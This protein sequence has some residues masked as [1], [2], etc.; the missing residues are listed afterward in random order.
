MGEAAAKALALIVHELATNSVKYGSLSSARGTLDLTCTEADGEIA[1]V[2]AERGRPGRH[3]GPDVPIQ[4]RRRPTAKRCGG[5]PPPWPRA[6]PF[7]VSARSGCALVEQ[8]GRVEEDPPS[9]ILGGSGTDPALRRSCQAMICTALANATISRTRRWPTWARYA[10]TGA[11]VAAVFLLR[12]AADPF[13]PP[14]YPY[15]LAFVAILLS[16]A[17]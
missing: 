10:T 9:G 13:L 7:C 15:L 11:I 14:V 12:R 17:L 3:P 16:G 5:P 8:R 4:R 2:W 1:V 6:A